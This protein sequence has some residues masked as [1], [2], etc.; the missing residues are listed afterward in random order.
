MQDTDDHQA[1][2]RAGGGLCQ[3]LEEIGLVRGICG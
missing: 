1:A 2:F 3:F